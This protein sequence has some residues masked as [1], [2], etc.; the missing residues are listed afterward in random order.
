MSKISDFQTATIDEI[1][2]EPVTI[3]HVSFE[4]G[5]GAGGE[6]YQRA[7]ITLDDGRIFRSSSQVVTD[8]LARVPLDAFPVGPLMFV[9]QPSNVKGRNDFITMVDAE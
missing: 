1:L 6:T 7:I 5:R 8:N 9:K 2:D 3:T 4:T